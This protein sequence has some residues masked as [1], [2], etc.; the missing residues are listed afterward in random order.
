MFTVQ[1][2][3]QAT[4]GSLLRKEQDHGQQVQGVS[5]DSRTIKAAEVFIAIKGPNFDGHDY[6]FQ[7]AE[8]NAGAVVCQNTW[9]EDNIAAAGRLGIPVIAVENSLFALSNLAKFHRQRFD[10]PIIAVTGSNG[11]TT[12]KDMIAWIL[13][14]EY[15]VLKSRASFNN[16]IGVPLTL[17]ELNQKHQA[18]V[19][20]MGMNHKGEI[21]GLAL[22]AMPQIGIITNTATA[23]IEFLGSTENIVEAKCEL[24][25][26]LGPNGLAIINA[27]CKALHQRAKDFHQQIIDFGIKSISAYQASNIISDQNGIAFTVNQRYTFRLNLLGEHNV[28]NALAAIAV[29]RHLKLNYDQIRQKLAEFMPVGL[30]MQIIKAGQADVI[31]DCYNA[32]PDSTSAAIRALGAMKDKKR[33][34]FVFGDMLELGKFSDQAHQQIGQLVADTTIAGLI[35][36]GPK[37]RLAAKEAKLCGMREDAV[38]ECQTNQEAADILNRI[39][40]KDDVILLKASRAMHLENIID[41]LKNNQR[42]G[43]NL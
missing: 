6:I 14:G 15:R 3:I 22:T 1:Q 12:T 34:L 5:I 21:R 26:S 9:L 39:I 41:L 36:I 18:A 7:A 16:H 10:I 2:I 31:A 42:A 30:R 28:Y 13:S 40:D 11:K 17:L 27:D 43:V 4:G 37:A 32:N 19:L 38:F 8:K 23:H 25:E 33:K 29:A 20:E 35:T 24:L